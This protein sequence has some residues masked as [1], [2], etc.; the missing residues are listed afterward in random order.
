MTGAVG[1]LG[2]FSANAI[3][4]GRRIAAAGGGFALWAF[5]IRVS[6]A[7]LAFLTQIV[8]ARLVGEEAYGEVAAAITVLGVVVAIAVLGLDTAAQR[9]VAHYRVE[10]D[11]ASLRGF[12][13]AARL[14]PLLLGCVIGAIGSAMTWNADP[15]LSLAFVMLPFVAVLLAQEGIA[16]AFDWPV[17]ALG[18]NFLLRPVLAL[19]LVLGAAGLGVGLDASV[20]I[21]AMLVAALVALLVQTAIVAPRIRAVVPAGERRYH[22]RSWGLV[23]SP[24]VVGDIGALVATSVDVIALSLTRPAEEVGIYFAAVKS[25]ALVQFVAYAVSNAVA[26]RV[27]ALHVAGDRAALRRMV[28]RACLATFVPSV[29]FAA[30]LVALGPFVLGLFGE[31]FVAAWPAMAIVAAGAVILA[32]VGP[33]ERVL[34]MIG[35]ERECALV[36]V[37]TAFVATLLA[38]WLAPLHGPVGAAIALSAGMVFEALAL[39]F[40]L[41]RALA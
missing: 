41:R 19:G 2:R 25:L 11:L 20:V 29:A 13:R 27:S 4:A 8:L 15:V 9:F 14:A 1:I 40:V 22:L 32:A 37:A 10:G 21:L 33:A 6:A 18:P 12:M 38:F 5:A 3:G 36:Y 26:H 31:A 39:A 35:K 7:A 28:V 23:V 34:N 17:V 16:K 24:I 30:A